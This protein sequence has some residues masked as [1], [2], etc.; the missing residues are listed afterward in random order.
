LKNW[1]QIIAGEM[2]TEE[3]GVVAVDDLTLQITTEV[4][5]PPLP[6]M[7]V[8]SFVMQKDALETHGPFYNNDPATSV[9]AGPFI[10]ESIEPGN[11]IVLAANPN[12][13]GS[14][15]PRLSKIIV[16]YMN[17]AT[18]FAAFQQGEIHQLGYEWLTP[19][20]FEIVM[21]DPVLSENY[22]RHYGDFR[23]DYLLFDTYNPPFDD[24]NVRK[25]FAHAVDRESIVRL[26]TPRACCMSIRLMIVRWRTNISLMPD[27]PV[28][29]ASHPKRCGYVAKAR[30][31]KQ[32]TAQQ[33]RRLPSA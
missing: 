17:I 21:N 25:A 12:Y 7:M 3:L 26:P 15:Q 24:L 11:Q 18:G 4:P 2:P 16:T 20:D 9:S 31:C 23:T 10:L 14:R 13:K 32:S 28:A 30:P 6:A 22:L 33:Q 5:W 19:A 8:F 1:N 29:K 27:S